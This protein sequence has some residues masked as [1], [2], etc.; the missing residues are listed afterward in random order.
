MSQPT[1]KKTVMEQLVQ[2]T[3]ATTQD[4]KKRKRLAYAFGAL[5]LLAVA[6]YFIRQFNLLYQSNA[7]S[8][9]PPSRVERLDS[10][11][12]KETTIT[13]LYELEEKNRHR[14]SIIRLEED[15][16]LD[17]IVMDWENLYDVRKKESS[18]ATDGEALPEDA[19]RASLESL[20]RDSVRQGGT[21]PK[22][23][24]AHRLQGTNTGRI[25][26]ARRR[27]TRSGNKAAYRNTV[28]G[29]TRVSAGLM[30]RHEQEKILSYE[31]SAV[32]PFNTGR[33]PD[34]K[35]VSSAQENRKTKEKRSTA[36]PNHTQTVGTADH[37]DGSKIPRVVPAV[38]HGDCKVQNGSKVTFRT[39]EEAVLE[40]IHLPVNTLI[41]GLAQLSNGR[42]TFTDF[43]VKLDGSS[44]T[45]PFTCY[46]LDMMAGI[47][48]GDQGMI[49]TEVRRGSTSAL[50]DAASALSN[51]IPHGALAR[52]SG[53]IARGVL[54]GA[55]RK[56]ESFIYLSD[57][58]KVFLELGSPK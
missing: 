13:R 56:R 57:G 48:Y 16:A 28:Y 49:E 6:G 53:N 5:L 30:R 19:S 51:A 50:A 58:Y 38:V 8:I 35:A 11:K 36:A 23:Y 29:N 14:D 41:T 37:T 4:Q 27:V 43:R 55:A 2:K 17:Y 52:A 12:G 18:Q 22:S 25:S 39:Q 24:L 54:R 31:K 34:S 7:N 42:I 15:K 32:D 40:G 33:A 1:P 46:D 3:R 20:L 21:P 26:A 9:A 10:T 45:L 47:S 44:V